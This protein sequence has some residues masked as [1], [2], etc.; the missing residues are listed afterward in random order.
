[1]ASV[2]TDYAAADE[3]TAKRQKQDDDI[4]TFGAAGNK[5]SKLMLQQ[6]LALF[7][8]VHA[9]RTTGTSFTVA[10][11]PFCMSKPAYLEMEKHI[12]TIEEVVKKHPYLLHFCISIKEILQISKADKLAN[13]IEQKVIN[14]EK[15]I[16][17]MEQEEARL[18]FSKNS[19]LISK[20]SLRVDLK[21]P[22]DSIIV[23]LTNG[24]GQFTDKVKQWYEVF[25]V[26]KYKN[27][28]LKPEDFADILSYECPQFTELLGK[29]RAVVVIFDPPYQSIS[30]DHNLHNCNGDRSISRIEF[31][32]RYGVS[33]PY[34]VSMIHC[35]YLKGFELAKKLLAPGGSFLVKLMNENGRDD[36]RQAVLNLAQCCGFKHKG[37]AYKVSSSNGRPSF[38]FVFERQDPKDIPFPGLYLGSDQARSHHEEIKLQVKNRASIDYMEKGQK[39]IRKATKWI[40]Y[41]NKLS[42]GLSEEQRKQAVKDIPPAITTAVSRFKENEENYKSEFDEGVEIGPNSWEDLQTISLQLNADLTGII[43]MCGLYFQQLLIANG[44]NIERGSME[45]KKELEKKIIGDNVLVWPKSHMN[46]SENITRLRTRCKKQKE[47]QSQRKQMEKFV[48]KL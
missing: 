34:T 23:D 20:V 37:E 13:Q 36:L 17:V 18:A 27:R 44:I 31:N 33:F 16:L 8:D 35:F 19:E 11:R 4:L 47:E 41:F 26:D 3:R 38:L 14:E 29:G 28:E 45:E 6:K 43:T 2:S 46:L 12:S 21:V 9:Q 48:V 5:Y 25:A 30:G 32:N 24:E 15:M 7:R 42:R 1:M 22:Q 10:L 39:M 40:C